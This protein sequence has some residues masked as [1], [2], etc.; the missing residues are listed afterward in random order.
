[1]LFEGHKHKTHCE[2]CNLNRVGRGQ[3]NQIGFYE[4]KRSQY[5]KTKVFL[6][7]STQMGA[8][9]LTIRTSDDV[10]MEVGTAVESFTKAQWR[11]GAH[12]HAPLG[13]ISV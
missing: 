7:K 9:N 2:V 10:L 8:L 13:Q 3:S 12:K 6:L 4:L 5:I 1:M 11:G